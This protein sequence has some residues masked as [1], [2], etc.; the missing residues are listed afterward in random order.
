[1]TKKVQTLIIENYLAD[2]NEIFTGSTHYEC[3]FVGGPMAPRWRQP[4]SLISEKN[5]N[6]SGLDKD[7]CTKFYGK[8]HHGDAEMTT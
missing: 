2:Y 8:I 5:V 3:A 4:L 7:I 6:N 1:M